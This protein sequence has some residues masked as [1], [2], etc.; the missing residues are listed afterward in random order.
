M[1]DRC[2][3]PTGTNFGSMHWLSF[4]NRN[5]RFRWN[6]RESAGLHD[7]WTRQLP[8]GSHRYLAVEAATRDGWRYVGPAEYEMGDLTPVCLL[9]QTPHDRA[10]PP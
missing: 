10:K 8:G 9:T 7:Y 5:F 1:T 3:P 4:R 2:E 6:S